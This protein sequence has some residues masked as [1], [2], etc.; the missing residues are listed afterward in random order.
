MAHIKQ[1]LIWDSFES[2]KDFA[3]N[4]EKYYK[5]DEFKLKG[6]DVRKF[7]NKIAIKRI[8]EQ[9]SK[10]EKYWSQ[11]TE[12]QSRN[13]SKFSPL[14]EDVN[15]SK[16]KSKLKNWKKY[17]SN[18][19]FQVI[20]YLLKLW[21]SDELNDID[22]NI[23]VHL[24]DKQLTLD[25]IRE[26]KALAINDYRYFLLNY[27]YVKNKLVDI[28]SA[29]KSLR[30]RIFGDKLKYVPYLIQ[31]RFLDL[32]HNYQ[33]V[34][35]VKT[36]Q[37]GF[38]TSLAGYLSQYALKHANKTILIISKSFEDAKETLE[39]S[40]KF[41]LQQ[42]PFFLRKYVQREIRSL[43][44]LGNSESTSTIRVMTSGKSSGRSI[45]ASILVLDEA[46]FIKNVDKLQSAAAPT[47]SATGGKGIVLSTP[48]E[49][50]QFQELVLN[51]DN[52]NNGQEIV[53]GYWR[54]IEDRTLDWYK[55]RIK[56]LNFKVTSIKTELEMEQIQPKAN[57]IAPTVL[58]NA[59]V[60]STAD[61]LES[62]AYT[63]ADKANVKNLLRFLPQVEIVKP[64][65]PKANDRLYLISVDTYEGGIDTN[66]VS[67]FEVLANGNV[68]LVASGKTK[69]ED[70]ASGLY[71]AA[72][73]LGNVLILVEKNRGYHLIHE[74]Y[75]LGLSSQLLPNFGLSKGEFKLKVK[76][77]NEWNE[78][79]N[80]GLYTTR[81][82]KDK[83]IDLLISY[84]SSGNAIPVNL[85]EELKYLK[86]LKSGRVEGMKGDD[87]IMSAS[88]GLVYLQVIAPVFNPKAEY[89]NDQHKQF[90][91]QFKRKFKKYLQFALTNQS[92]DNNK[93]AYFNAN[94]FVNNID[95]NSTETKR[96][97]KQKWIYWNK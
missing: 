51:A 34:V 22:K 93:I 59:N 15:F 29:P 32:V 44:E 57:V 78:I 90:V 21:K 43:V 5:D 48:E 52:G 62:N 64:V 73:Y 2:F 66:A 49:P 37:I 47:L 63:P 79:S 81:E 46:N 14:T 61:I 50:G 19:E 4:F 35:S 87:I 39:D 12:Y 80:I 10:L 1:M 67:I 18:E 17:Y 94:K 91:R 53:Q 16:W 76:S 33:R 96:S 82:V 26:E 31:F 56:D 65:Y 89:I 74:L 8:P 30:Y 70:I 38:T 85:Y 24:L 40:V 84:V 45:S 77:I 95:S 42:L 6:I 92:V 97:S 41:P 9:L 27:W 58:D 23:L 36:R 3:I 68:S 55:S 83:G 75:N 13:F 25:E 7:W 71:S 60:K 69:R 20:A 86:V 72:T 11:Y 28:E 54:L 88:I